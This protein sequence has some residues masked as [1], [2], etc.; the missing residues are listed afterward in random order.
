[1]DASSNGP[2]VYQ[3]LDQELREI[4][5]LTILPGAYESPIECTLENAPFFD[6]EDYDALSYTWGDP[7]ITT[8]MFV[9]GHSFQAT[10]NLAAALV[11]LRARHHFRLWID[12]VCIDQNNRQEKGLQVLRMEAI[13]RK[14]NRTIVWLGNQEDHSDIAFEAFKA[15]SQDPPDE[16]NSLIQDFRTAGSAT[17]AAVKQLFRR[18]YWRRVWIIQEVSVSE[19][20]I[21]YCGKASR[22]WDTLEFA[23][24]AIIALKDKDEGLAQDFRFVED[25]F[26]TLYRFRLAMTQDRPLDLLSALNRSG[27]TLATCPRDRVFALLGIT[28]DGKSYISDPNYKQDDRSIFI[29]MA[30]SRLFHTRDLDIICL[31]AYSPSNPRDLPSWVPDWL[32]LGQ[33]FPSRMTEYLSGHGTENFV[34]NAYGKSPFGHPATFNASANSTAPFRMEGSTLSVRGIF[35][36]T[37]DGLTSALNPDSGY[38][39]DSMYSDMSQPT[40]S[41]PSPYGSNEELFKSLFRTMAEFPDSMH[42]IPHDRYKTTFS[43]L[44]TPSTIKLL[45]RWTRFNFKHL[46]VWLDRNKDFLI[47]DQPL[48]DYLT[49]STRRLSS[50]IDRAHKKLFSLSHDTTYAFD[51][52]PP[53]ICTAAAVRVVVQFGIRI[54]TT[55]LGYVGRAHPAA[56]KGDILALIAGCSFPVILRRSETVEERFQVVGDAYVEGWMDGYK[57]NQVSTKLHDIVLE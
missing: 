27:S 57:W 56:Q 40:S 15:L 53:E 51:Y 49:G 48:E 8:E 41:S 29:D 18:P 54:I 35:L 24:K 22:K 17:R 10:L 55:E 11:E 36:D 25:Y 32:N 34:I 13:Y 19:N 26:L 30:K 3:P 7:Q 14:A 39:V 5:I 37:V 43:N 20:V 4:R 47:G 6:V 45:E 46:L 44:M 12:A 28:V 16:Q 50:F 33:I 21:I 31:K 38:K 2:L 52:Y 1:M 9:N 23:F 42:G